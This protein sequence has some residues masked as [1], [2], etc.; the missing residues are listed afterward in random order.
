MRIFLIVTIL[1]AELFASNFYYE[2]GEKVELIPNPTIKSSNSV[3]TENSKD[4]LEYTTTTGKIVK[5]KNEIIVKCDKSAYCEDDFSDLSLTNYKKIYDNIYLLKLDSSDDI[6]TLCQKL[7][8][9]TDIVSAHP[10]YVREVKAK[11]KNI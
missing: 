6:F 9:K 5:F 2:F 1:V 11:W 4:I 3:Q 10:N 7:Y 8:E